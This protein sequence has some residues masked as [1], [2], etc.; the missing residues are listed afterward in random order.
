MISSHLA[1][2]ANANLS[3]GGTNTQF[4][5][6]QQPHHAISAIDN[7]FRNLQN[8]QNTIGESKDDS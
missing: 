2:V 6:A 1:S 4:P 5:P 7:S 8:L 3:S